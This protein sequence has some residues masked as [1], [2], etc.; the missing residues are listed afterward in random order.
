[1]AP[2]F[3]GRGLAKTAART[4][5]RRRFLMQIWSISSFKILR[6][7]S[8]RT[9]TSRKRAGIMRSPSPGDSGGRL[10][11]P[12]GVIARHRYASAR[13]AAAGI[14]SLMSSDSSHR[15]RC[16]VPTPRRTAYRRRPASCSLSSN[17]PRP[18]FRW[19]HSS[20]RD[21]SRVTR[22]PHGILF[23]K[24]LIAPSSGRVS[25]QKRLPSGMVGLCLRAVPAPSVSRCGPWRVSSHRMHSGFS[26]FTAFP[27]PALRGLDIPSSF[28]RS[29]WRS[30]RPEARIHAQQMPE[31]APNE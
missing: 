31:K 9:T 14:A 12:S 6:S 26:A 16:L 21:L 22:T 4:R 10:R 8:R 15:F 29:I 30:R 20:S 25:G 11:P 23:E 3:A 5:P 27:L 19:R 24:A 1:V 18:R 13:G 7:S 28:A 2:A 17:K